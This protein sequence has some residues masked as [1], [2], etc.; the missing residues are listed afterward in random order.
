MIPCHYVTFT[1]F[2]ILGTSIFY[3][4]LTIS[5]DGVCPQ[6]VTTPPRLGPTRRGAAPAARPPTPLPPDPLQVNIHFFVDGIL[7]TFLGVFLITT[8]RGNIKDVDGSEA[9]LD[10]VDVD[11]V[12]GDA[13]EGEEGEE[14]GEARESVAALPPPGSRQSSARSIA[15]STAGGVR[16]VAVSIDGRQRR[17]SVTNP[18][19]IDQLQLEP[20]KTRQSR[21]ASVT[22]FIGALGGGKAMMMHTFDPTDHE[23]EAPPEDFGQEVI[24]GQVIDHT[25]G[26]RRASLSFSGGLGGLRASRADLG[27]ASAP[28]SA[29]GTPTP[30]AGKEYKQE[31]V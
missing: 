7:L 9:G 11:A 8:G 21:A 1:L 24:I 18:F 6:W 23:K 30:T 12:E 29:H 10:D 3:H 25:T 19:A 2:S 14:G 5:K 28:A 4:E 17:E 20:G 31:T 27:A 26:R 16:P 15:G 22:A 13:A